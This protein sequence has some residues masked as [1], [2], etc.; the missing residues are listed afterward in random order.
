MSSTARLA[1]A[2]AVF[3]ALFSLVFSAGS[4]LGVWPQPPRGGFRGTDLSAGF[5][6]G[7]VLLAALCMPR[8][9][10]PLG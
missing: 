5:A 7:L 6:F 2:G 1:A 8:R 4:A 9:R 10:R 3:L